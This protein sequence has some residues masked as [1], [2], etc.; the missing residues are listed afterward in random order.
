MNESPTIDETEVETS[1]LTSP[2]AIIDDL[3]GDNALLEW[4]IKELYIDSLS[5]N[6][7]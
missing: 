6:W 5:D 2:A 7:E 1:Y 3:R 4:Q